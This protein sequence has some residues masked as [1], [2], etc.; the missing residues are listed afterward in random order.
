[1][2]QQQQEKEYTF[3]PCKG[4]G[5]R[6]SISDSEVDMLTGEMITSSMICSWCGGSGN[7]LDIGD[8]SDD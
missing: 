4:C 3:E 1:M 2:D 8:T 6:G 5:G 7:A